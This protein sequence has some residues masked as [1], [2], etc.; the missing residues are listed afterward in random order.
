MHSTTT[1]ARLIASV[2]Q[3]AMSTDGI[4]IAEMAKGPSN[5]HARS[6]RRIL[7][8]STTGDHQQASQFLEGERTILLREL[9][10]PAV[11]TT[12]YGTL[13]TRLINYKNTIEMY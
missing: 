13:S 10:F 12:T 11:M 9:S 3:I 1:D 5:L 4:A 8:F 2:V 7:A 6:I